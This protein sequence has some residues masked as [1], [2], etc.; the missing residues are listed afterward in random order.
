MSFLPASGLETHPLGT[1]GNLTSII[2]ANWVVLDGLIQIM[3]RFIKTGNIDGKTTATSS[4]ANTLG[5]NLLV[6]RA[7]LVPVT[8]T[9]VSGNPTLEL[10]EDVSGTAT[11]AASSTPAPTAAQVHQFTLVTGRPMILTPSGSLKTKVTTAATGTAYL[12]QIWLEVL[13]K[14]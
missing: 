3:P 5:Y 1:T 6:L 9:S 2:D 8:F 4:F 11:L 14:V 13:L 7:F 10:G 12:F